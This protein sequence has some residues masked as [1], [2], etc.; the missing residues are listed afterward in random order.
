MERIMTPVPAVRGAGQAVEPGPRG[1]APELTVVIPTFCERENIALV[2][3]RVDA[4]L[5]GVAWEII[6]VDDDS[7]DGTA[8][9]INAIA[10]HD[11]RIRG[12][13]RVGRRGLAG[14]CIEGMLASQAPYVAVMDADLQHDE[15]LLTEMLERLYGGYDVAVGSRRLETPVAGLTPARQS[16]SRLANLVTRKLFGIDVSDPMTGFFMLRRSLIE[17]VAPR[18]SPHGFKL[19]VDILAS[20]GKDVRVVDLPF[21]FRSRQHGESKLD[22]QVVI[23]FLELLVAKLSHG[24][25]PDRF[26]SFMLVGLSGI[27]VHL[28]VLA[29]MHYTTAI[30]FTWAQIVATGAAMASNFFLNN[31]LTY[32]AQR[33]SGIRAA[34]GL[35]V[36]SLICS[37]GVVSNIGVASWIYTQ[38]HSWWFAGLLG[39]IVSAVWNYAV[40]RTLVWRVR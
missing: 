4:A 8:A 27:G 1:A 10:A 5:A 37:V 12:I 35:V 36:F 39:S 30:S 22:N 21:D 33:L 2:I 29:I 9:E 26:V 11:A 6:F 13:R 32:R 25:V 15:R 16:G 38:D 31:A 7:P 40:S 28:V 23:D 24:L 17:A 14:A 19:L 18:L 34:I 3:E 20:A